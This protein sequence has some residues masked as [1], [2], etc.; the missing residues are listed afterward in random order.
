LGAWERI[1][2]LNILV[3]LQQIPRFCE[4]IQHFGLG[5]VGIG[6][7]K[8]PV[9]TL[10]KL[11]GQLSIEVFAHKDSMGIRLGRDQ[12]KLFK[13]D[14]SWI[15]IHHS[16]FAFRE[17][18]FKFHRPLFG[19]NQTVSI[20][21]SLED[22]INSSKWSAHLLGVILFHGE[23]LGLEFSGDFS[24]ISFNFLFCFL[25]EVFV[26]SIEKSE[27]EAAFCGFVLC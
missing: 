6:P 3:L 1:K 25:V 17:S 27:E 24:P 20:P 11:V 10:L 16:I 15:N 2:S 19:L 21:F 22:K 26:F 8:W 9:F 18:T 5:V 13:A 14:A 4:K 12:E 7:G 23:V